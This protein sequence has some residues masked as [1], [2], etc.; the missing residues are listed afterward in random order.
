MPWLDDNMENPVGMVLAQRWRPQ[1]TFV[2]P[3]GIS[4]DYV[5]VYSADDAPMLL[6]QTRW[7]WGAVVAPRAVGDEIISPQAPE[8]AD[9]MVLQ[10]R[11]IPPVQIAIVGVSDDYAPI[12]P[13]DDYMTVEVATDFEVDLLSFLPRVFWDEPGTPPIPSDDAP[14]LPILQRP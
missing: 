4:D 14:M 10:Y 6:G 3:L 9:S 2:I 8:D 11:Q 13:V 1:A 5:P 7:D 12:P